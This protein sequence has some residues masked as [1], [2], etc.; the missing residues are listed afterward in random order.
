MEQIKS[1][2]IT[3][4][5]E[6]PYQGR[7]VRKLNK[8]GKT[9]DPNMM[10]LMESI[11]SKGLMMP[12]IVR[13]I[14]DN[15]EIIDG[16]RRV[17]AF[18]RLG[19]TDIEAIEK[20]Y[21]DKDAQVFSIVGNLM[22]QNLN[23][24]EKALAFKKIM[25]TQD[26]KDVKQFSKAIGKHDSF[27]GDILNTLDM[28]QRIINDL[29]A[30]KTTEDVRLLRAIRK[31]DKAKKNKSDKQWELYQRFKNENLSRN[32]VIK[33]VKGSKASTKP[34]KI[35]GSGKSFSIHF[36]KKL[37]DDKKAEMIQYLHGKVAEWITEEDWRLSKD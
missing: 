9:D 10:A 20:E 13:P 2:A 34:F 21:D 15:F 32:R 12:I 24:I 1:I 37:S 27:V 11:K 17:E 22:R 29:I 31:Y 14:G 8:K 5:V 3:S 28:D 35:E 30:N 23:L 25:A 16:H 19:K 6:S 33:E 7:L 4:L 18:R 36:D 26:F